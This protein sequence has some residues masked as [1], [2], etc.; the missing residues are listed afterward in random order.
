MNHWQKSVLV[1]ALDAQTTLTEDAFKEYLQIL[2]DQ[3]YRP[4]SHVTS[5]ASIERGWGVCANCRQPFGDWPKDDDQEAYVTW[6]GFTPPNEGAFARA[7]RE[8]NESAVW[9]YMGGS[10]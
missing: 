1:D 10:E 3:A 9:H 7:L 5:R 6:L 4:C 2:E 8:H